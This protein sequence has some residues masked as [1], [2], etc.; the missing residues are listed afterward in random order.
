MKQCSCEKWQTYVDDSAF[1]NDPLR[2]DRPMEPHYFGKKISFCPWCGTAL[3]PPIKG[4]R[5][6][7]SEPLD[8]GTILEYFVTKKEY[9][10]GKPA[11]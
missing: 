3:Q 2:G 11:P 1:S 9:K 7:L 6:K 8:D 4:G 10:G 5:A